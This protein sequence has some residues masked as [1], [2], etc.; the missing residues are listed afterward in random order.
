[1]PFETQMRFNN[2]G[3][4]FQTNSEIHSTLNSI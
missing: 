1:L 3:R 4:V 2:F